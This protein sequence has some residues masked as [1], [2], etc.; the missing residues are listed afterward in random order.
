ME[1][2]EEGEE[3]EEFYDDEEED[4]VP[5]SNP[6]SSYGSN[7]GEQSINHMVHLFR[8]Q[9]LSQVKDTDLSKK[10]QK[11]KP[12]SQEHPA[13]Q[14]PNKRRKIIPP[15]VD[16]INKDPTYIDASMNMK[17]RGRGTSN[18]GRGRGVGRGRGRG[19]AADISKSSN[20]ADG[21]RGMHWRKPELRALI[22]GANHLKPVLKG[23]FKHSN[24]GKTMKKLA[25]E[26]LSGKEKIQLNIV[27]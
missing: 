20:K 23:K 3:G 1:D 11:G 10:R 27:Y 6:M 13:H 26:E 4:D 7:G 22:F 8:Q 9:L 16:D 5:S 17:P 18:R 25:W 2:E 14:G 15:P 21:S 24:D 19:K 12:P